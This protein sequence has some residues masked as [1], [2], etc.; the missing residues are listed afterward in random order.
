[1]PQN[2]PYKGNLLAPRAGRLYV[3]RWMTESGTQVK[4]RYFT[5]PFDAVA[6]YE[7]LL[8][9]DKETGVWSADTAWSPYLPA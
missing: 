8:G 9:F 1:M 7:R 3:V 4:H 5:R 6:S 2:T